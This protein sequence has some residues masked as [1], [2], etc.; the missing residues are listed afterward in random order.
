[1]MDDGWHTAGN[2]GG[3]GGAIHVYKEFSKS[4]VMIKKNKRHTYGLRGP[5]PPSPLLSSS[6]L[7]L[8][9]LP[10]PVGL[11]LRATVGDG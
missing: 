8:L 10:L 9:L 7:L 1:M 5:M 4:F 6:S 2:S 11:L 3:G